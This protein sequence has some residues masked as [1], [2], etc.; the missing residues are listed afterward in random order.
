MQS[1]STA[2]QRYQTKMCFNLK[3]KMQSKTILLFNTSNFPMIEYIGMRYDCNRKGME[4][5]DRRYDH[6][7][8]SYILCYLSD[9]WMP[10][11]TAIALPHQDDRFQLHH[12]AAWHH[13]SVDHSGHWHLT[14]PSAKPWPH[15][16][17]RCKPLSHMIKVN[18]TLLSA[19]QAFL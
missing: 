9:W 16:L 7:R 8:H 6:N 15:L 10:H 1:A 17:K 3:K 18:Q 2:T 4:Y 19:F 11:L 13:S 5:T 14:L 12:E